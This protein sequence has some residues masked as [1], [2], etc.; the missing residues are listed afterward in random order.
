MK[1]DDLMTLALVAGGGYLLYWYLNNYG[2]NGAAFSATGVQVGPT[3]WQQW[4]GG[5][6]T[7]AVA[8]PVTTAPAAGATGTVS[9]PAATTVQLNDVSTGATGVYAAGDSFQLI[10][11]G[12]PNQPVTGTASFNG[13]A[14]SS[15]Q[16]GTT[17]ANG[18]K[19]ITGSWDSTDVGVWQE[20]WQVGQ[21]QPVSLNFTINPQGSGLQGMGN[22]VDLPNL[23]SFGGGKG[24]SGGFRGPFRKSMVN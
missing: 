2:P 9:L 10:V 19:I 15:S 3:Y 17:D 8:A 18:Q 21:A 23:P 22:I 4:F 11:K 12:P 24:F 13:G 14:V 1:K 20:T 7:P 16:F 6:T 5:T